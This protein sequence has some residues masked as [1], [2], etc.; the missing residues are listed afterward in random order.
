MSVRSGPEGSLIGR[1]Q[2]RSANSLSV[3]RTLTAADAM[4]FVLKLV[5]IE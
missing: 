3:W 4:M 1:R 5:V 2:R